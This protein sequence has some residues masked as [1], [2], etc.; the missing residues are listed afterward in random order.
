MTIELWQLLGAMMVPMWI[1]FIIL[2]QNLNRIDSKITALASRPSGKERRRKIVI[3]MNHEALRQ[4]LRGQP[5]NY[6]QIE[7]QLV[8][9]DVRDIRKI[10]TDFYG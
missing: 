7:V 3:G 10:M 1:G 5:L 4:L 8:G 9:V 2:Y 6:E